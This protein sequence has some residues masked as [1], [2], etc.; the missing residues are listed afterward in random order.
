MIIS[1]IFKEN[2][3]NELLSEEFKSNYFKELDKKE[4]IVFQIAK[5]HV[6]GKIE[7]IVKEL[8]KL[9][10]SK[11]IKIVLLP[12]GQAAYHSDQVPLKEIYMKLKEKIDIIYIDTKNIYDVMYVLA[13]TTLY[14][15]TSLHG[16]ITAFSYGRRHVALTS[17]ISKQREFL[18]TW[19]L[20]DIYLEIEDIS[21]DID[22]Y[23]YQNIEEIKRKSKIAKEKVK[24][25]YEQI[26]RIMLG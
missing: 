7:I 15:G 18:K 11:R 4:Y 12:I 6:K 19:S 3:L 14:L 17:K 20:G 10:M 13:N 9:Y 24:E 23:L 21:K 25:N 16:A 8:E 1:D 22:L 2:I 5:Q 26:R